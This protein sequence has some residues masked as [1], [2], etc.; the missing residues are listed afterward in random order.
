MGVKIMP[1]GNPQ[2][3]IPNSERTPEEL[4]EQT[5]RAGIASGVARREKK[6]FRET[7]EMCLQELVERKGEDGSVLGKIT[8][9]Q[10]IC[11]KQIA[12]AIKGDTPAAKYC[13]EV[14]TPKQIEIT[15][16]DGAPLETKVKYITPESIEE[17]K[18]HIKDVVND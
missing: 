7:M 12:K 14:S 13:A 1:R 17:I 6:T 8:A 11:L 2:N 18:K 9:Q 4:R 3:L 15:G 10:A 5:R 16:K